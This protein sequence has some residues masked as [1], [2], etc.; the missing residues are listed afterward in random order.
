MSQV[1]IWIW[2]IDRSSKGAQQGYYIKYGL[3]RM[4][5]KKDETRLYRSLISTYIVFSNLI[6]HFSNLLLHQGREGINR[7][8]RHC[9]YLW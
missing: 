2:M 5:K 6:K 7:V 8:E 1:I 4:R 3:M 9:Y